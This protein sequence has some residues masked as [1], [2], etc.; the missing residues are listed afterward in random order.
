MEVKVE[1]VFATGGRGGGP[2]RRS[3]KHDGGYN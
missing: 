3:E 1:V 2:D